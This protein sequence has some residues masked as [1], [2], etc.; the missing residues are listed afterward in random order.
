MLKSLFVLFFL[1]FSMVLL[2][3]EV[4]CFGFFEF[5]WFCLGFH[6]IRTHSQPA[7]P[8]VQPSPPSSTG[9]RP[10]P[11]QPGSQSASVYKKTKGKLKKTKKTKHPT[12]NHSKTIEK[13]KKKLKK[14]KISATM[15]VRI[16]THSQPASPG[17][18]PSQPASPGAP[19]WPRQGPP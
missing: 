2:G 7:S 3:F 18:Q 17:A 15:G 9:A 14:T 5:F 13:T 1:V 12:S 19:A 11:A 16:G 4:G 8:G 6:R 10:S